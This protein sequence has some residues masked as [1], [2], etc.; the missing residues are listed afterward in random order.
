MNNGWIKLHRQII[1]NPIFR[2]DRTAW[3]VF[4]TLLIIADRKGEWSGGMYQ[5][6][7]LVGEKK[8]TVYKAVQRLVDSRMVN[9]LVNSRYTVY[10]ICK[11]KEYQGDGKQLS[12]QPVNSGETAGNTLTRKKN[13]KVEVN[14]KV[15]TVDKRNPEIKL[16]IEHFEKQIGKMPRP[17]YQ[18]MAA[19]ELIKDHSFQKVIGAINATAMTRG[20]PYAPNISSLEELRDKWIKLENFLG[21]AKTTNKPRRNI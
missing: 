14:T 10:S 20:Q 19:S 6:S 13:K 16:V 11:W 1:D 4:E 2:H 21:R 9:T 7:E 12:K 3:H 8:P 5:L 15:L 18:P 17:S